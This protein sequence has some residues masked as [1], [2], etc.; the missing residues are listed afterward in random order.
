MSQEDEEETEKEENKFEEVVSKEDENE[1]DE[2]EKGADKQDGEES[3]AWISMKMLA[4]K[5]LIMKVNLI[6]RRT[7]VLKD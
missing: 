7:K 2:P 4:R 1:G 6:K 5:H 3:P